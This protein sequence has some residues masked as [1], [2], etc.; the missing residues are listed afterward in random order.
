MKE[1][2]DVDFEKDGFCGV[3]KIIEFKGVVT[4]VKV[5]EMYII[6][7]SVLATV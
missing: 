4:L 7:K 6:M 5:D 2:K 3:S 1:E